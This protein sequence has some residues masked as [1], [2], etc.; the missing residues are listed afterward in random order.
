MT[1]VFKEAKIKVTLQIE[2]GIQQDIRKTLNELSNQDTL[3]S[4]QK[5]R[6][7]CKLLKECRDYIKKVKEE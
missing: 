7:Q 2:K 5:L 6:K 1:D 4:K 3:Q